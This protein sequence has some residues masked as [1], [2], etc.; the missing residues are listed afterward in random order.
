[1]TSPS[2]GSSPGGSIPEWAIRNSPAMNILMVAVLV[3]GFLS[4]AGMQRES[5]PSFDIDTILV[6][7]PYPGAAPQEVEEGICQKVEEAVRSLEGVK[8]VTSVASEGSGSVVLELDSDVKSPDRILDEVRAEI[9]RIPSFPEEAEDPEIRRVTVRRSAIRVGVIGPEDAGPSGELALREYAERVRDDLLQLDGV[10]QVDLI[11]ARDYQIDIEIA[12]STLREHGLSLRGVA[13]TV[14]REN[15]EL[16]AGTLRGSSQEVLLRGNNRRTTG[17][18]VAELP[19]ISQ[20]N[21]AVLTVGDLGV[22]RDEFTDTASLAEINGRPAIALSVER[23][24]E[25]DMLRMVDAVKQYAATAVP[26]PGYGLTTWSDQTVEVRGRLNLLYENALL[27]LCIVFFLLIFFLDLRLAFWVAMGIP[28]AV[29]GSAAYLY[30]ADASLNMISMFAFVMA[31]GIVVDDAI[32]VGE[33]IYAHHQMGKPLRRAAADGAAEVMP[34]ILTSVGTT[35]VAFTPM[36]FVSG[37]MGKFM[38]VM[39]AAV[40]A[41]LIASLFESLTILP[42]HLAHRDGALFKFIGTVLYAFRWLVPPIHKANEFAGRVLKRFIETVYVPVLRAS[43]HNRVVAVSGLAALLI[44]ATG[45]VR[46]GIV[47]FVIFPKLDGN[48]I[49]AS[50]AFPDG[51]PEAI[52]RT[53]TA[54]LEAAFWAVNERLSPSGQSLGQ[55]SFRV[56]GSQLANTDPAAGQANTSSGSHLGSVE[57][58]LL[59][60]E[61]REMSSE[62]IVAAWREEVGEVPGAE[63]LSI[64]ARAVGPQGIPIEFK[65][66]APPEETD[67]L[68]EVVELCKDK[69]E[70]FPGVF[71]I[72]DDSIPGKW[73][74]RFRIKPSAIAMGVRTADLAETVRAAYYG[75]EV[76]RVQ[77]GRHEV[78]IMVR[79]PREDR[80]RLAALDELRVRTGD[81]IERPI[82]ELAEIEIVRGYSELNRLDQRRSITVSAD[83]DEAVANAR[84]IVA[85]LRTEFLPE[86]L[87]DYPGVQVRWEGQQEQTEES[88]SSLFR[89][90]GVAILVMFVLLSFELKSYWQPL[91]I[92]LVIPF[93]AIGAIAGHALLGM[94]LTMFSMFGLVGLTGIVVNDSIVLVDF[95]NARVRSGMPLNE[96][97]IEAGRRRF[98]PVMLTT[99]T[100]I[101]GLLPILLETSLQAQILIPMATSIAFGEV[102]ATVVVLGLVPVG[103]SICT[104]V[105][106]AGLHEED[107][108]ATQQHAGG[109]HPESRA[110]E[111]LAVT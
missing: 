79:Y 53:T 58:E 25:E 22:V 37:V 23:S 48:T 28:F 34:S 95:I 31:L 110:T 41:M 87:R 21:G 40:I 57:L 108:P 43:L 6:T 92:L 100:T 104:S 51:T 94:P 7:F 12:E 82:T 65:L 70:T 61:Q 96:A 109:E 36:L 76:M 74:Y 17:E 75:E 4:F 86:V 69:L 89:G 30:F 103:Y 98:R 39:P 81:G 42:A 52:T 91:L 13:E 2:N 11:G 99:V 78:K 8:K 84:N 90:F 32:V 64:A 106:G 80:R 85:F 44:A 9:D 15:R 46:S 18:G 105:F 10:T 71:D 47:P 63:T 35:I 97:L 77:R 60:T 101:G 72:S 93:G 19:L 14:R 66:L 102:F 16:P 20:E 26:P 50:V 49:A 83:V 107:E 1:M 73:E 55:T 111:A 27:G 62:Q 88:I 56:V 59:D 33:N 67:K 45:L 54:R 24:S 5:F 3:V 68:E 29:L 38:A